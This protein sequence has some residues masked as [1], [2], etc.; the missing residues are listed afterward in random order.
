MR[1]GNYLFTLILILLSIGLCLSQQS[2]T[3]GTQ[4]TAANDSNESAEIAFPYVAQITGNHVNIRSGPGTD[5]YSCGKLN[6]ADRVIVVSSKFSWAQ[7]VP[8]ERSFSWISKQYVAV[9]PNNSDIGTVTGNNVRVYAGS[10]NLRPMHSTSLQIKHNKGEKVRLLGEEKDGYFK[11]APPEGAYL[12][13]L[14]Q[15]TEPIGALGEVPVRVE[16]AALSPETADT[17]TTKQ[18]ETETKTGELKKY[19]DVQKQF[20]AERARPLI[21]QD[22][23]EIKKK[24]KDIAANKQSDK[25][26][27][28]AQYTLGLISRCEL[29]ISAAKQ[30]ELQE[31]QLQH[32]NRRIDKAYSARLEKIA[33]LGR[34]A[35]VGRLERSN[36]YGSEGRLRYYRIL[37]ED[38]T[39]LCYA[40]PQ[41]PIRDSE[42]EKFIGK[43]VGLVGTVKPHKQASSA[44]VNFTE[45]VK[46]K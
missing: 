42:L 44:M 24:L 35:V 37:G 15:Y 40:N 39:T 4:K 11:I 45:I 23:T 21:E 12:W 43:K 33:D 46:L 9:E 20:D 8:P 22:Y 31:R 30:L 41:G 27:R 38:D 2:T 7:I 34:F 36:V 16:R 29:A 10:E 17:G 3:A 14:S 28:Y 13:V 6:K 32:I 1:A 19:Y 18:P 26:A 25:A 5:Y